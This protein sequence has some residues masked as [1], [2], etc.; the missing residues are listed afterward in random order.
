[1]SSKEV[2]VVYDARQYFS[3]E[4]LFDTKIADWNYLMSLT[5]GMFFLFE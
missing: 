3:D 2:F 5:L 1:M 4:S